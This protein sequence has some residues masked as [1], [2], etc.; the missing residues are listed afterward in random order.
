MKLCCK[1]RKR[2]LLTG[3]KDPTDPLSMYRLLQTSDRE[4][5]CYADVPYIFS[6]VRH[7]DEADVKANMQLR[8]DNNEKEK[9]LSIDQDKAKSV[10]SRMASM[11]LQRGMFMDMVVKK[12]GS[13]LNKDHVGPRWFDDS[14]FAWPAI[15]RNH[16][17]LLAIGPGGSGT[18][19]HAH[20]GAWNALIAGRKHWTLFPPGSCPFCPTAM[21]TMRFL[22]EIE[23]HQTLASSASVL[24][25]I[26]FP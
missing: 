19:L 15:Y 6:Q 26:K 10:K 14:R 22:K 17:L 1:R 4:N 8:N 16:D 23:V 11:S 2:V 20:S 18:I 9:S 24:L 5:D 25:L 3:G 13:E 12:D 7:Y 21:K